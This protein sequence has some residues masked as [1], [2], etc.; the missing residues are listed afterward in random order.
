MRIFGLPLS[1]VPGIATWEDLKDPA[2][3]DLMGAEMI[4]RLGAGDT[5]VNLAATTLTANAWL[6]DHNDRFA[7]WTLE[8]LDAWQE[9]AQ[10]NGGLLPDNTGPSGVVG[11]LQHGRWYGG[12]YGWNWPHGVYS[13]GS[14]ACVA[15]LNGVV[16]TGDA[17]RLDVARQL[18]DH[19]YE[20][21]VTAA[22]D[23][24]ELSI[25]DRWQAELGEDCA[26]P[27]LLIPNRH[28]DDGWFDYQ[29]PQL[30]LPM[31]LWQTAF[32]SSDRDRLTALRDRS[33]YD[34]RT[35]HDF[36]NKE[37][38]GHEAPWLAY[39][40][41]D[42][43]GYPEAMLGVAL[44]QVQRRM[45]LMAADTTDPAELNIHHWQ[46]HNPVATE[47]LLQLTTGTP[48][49]LYNGGLLP[50]HVLYLDPDRGRPGL[51]PDVAALVDTVEPDRT[52][53]Q[54]VNLSA[55]QTRRVIVQAGSFGTDRI[56]DAT[57]STATGE[58]PGPSPAYTSPPPTPGTRTVVVGGNRLEV[59]MP[60]GRT[61]RLDLRLT[62]NTYRAAHL[63]LI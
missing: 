6:Y 12:L 11:E 40:A 52:G 21:G 16:L 46:R 28:G 7:A 53:L 50:L 5:A 36:R 23:E 27:T 25:R 43:P 37:D 29:P 44:S 62:R 45:D 34:W 4:R 15:A 49:L 61:I 47:A 59:V 33:G 31:W 14:A 58:Y 56:D 18:L 8:Y 20:R 19:L 32:D 42:N 41:G 38:A 10:A 9:R 60:P 30:G 63:A 13:V 39:L 24:T 3:A 2:N 51:P 1:G 57:V 48:Q 55:T 26:K 54:L 22:V 35:V 17:K